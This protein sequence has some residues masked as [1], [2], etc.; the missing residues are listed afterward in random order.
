MINKT[1]NTP[2][3]QKDLAR[4]TVHSFYVGTENGYEVWKHN[5][6]NK[7]G[8]YYVRTERKIIKQAS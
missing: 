2:E 1:P 5:A 8:E 4:G 6:K 7:D 3:Q